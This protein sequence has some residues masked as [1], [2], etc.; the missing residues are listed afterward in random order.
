MDC[1][2]HPTA[3]VQFSQEA[4]LHFQAVAQWHSD[5]PAMLWPQLGQL[6]LW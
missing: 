3:D 4:E 6:G 1:Q 2:F 5:T